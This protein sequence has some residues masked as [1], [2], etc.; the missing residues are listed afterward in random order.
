MTEQLSTYL[1]KNILPSSSKF[2]SLEGVML[3]LKLQHFGHLMQRADSF[4]KTL[5]LGKI[6]GR[7]RR[8]RW[9]NKMVGWHHWLDGYVFEQAPGD[10]DGQGSLACCSPWGRKVRHNWAT[11]QQKRIP[12]L[13]WQNID[14]WS[15]CQIMWS[16]DLGLG[17]DLHF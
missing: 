15:S 5:R 12:W 10:G 8:G 14:F 6:E 3:K 17:R 7:R 13:T 9:E 4:E 16:I 11:E 2:N 1:V